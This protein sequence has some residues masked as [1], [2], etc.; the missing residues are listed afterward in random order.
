MTAAPSH[1]AVIAEGALQALIAG[2][3]DTCSFVALFGLFTAH[4]TGNLVLIGASIVEYRSGLIGK[5]L[6]L[7]VFILA[8]ALCRALTLALQSR[9]KNAAVPLLGLQL[10]LLAGF[11]GVGVAAAPVT[12]GDAPL[13]MLAGMLGVAAMAI[14]NTLS[15]TLFAGH[16]PTTV[17]TG[18]VTQLVIDLADRAL[19]HG[20]PEGRTRLVKMLPAV[21]AFTG[22]ALLG[23]VGYTLVGFWCLL[24]PIVA[25]AVLLGRET[26]RLTRSSYSSAGT[27]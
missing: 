6:A 26:R 27:Q 16:A 7:P 3:V 21:L 1:R 9:G 19:G 14:Q 8:V 5:L 11:M 24:V 15:R 10:L 25:L 20:T 17:M 2:F 4:V 12:D 13:A 22:G 18:N 23:A